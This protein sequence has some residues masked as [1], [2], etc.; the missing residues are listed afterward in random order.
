MQ[1]FLF[2]CAGWQAARGV[3]IPNVGLQDLG[4]AVKLVLIHPTRKN[5]LNK[6]E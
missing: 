5:V 2:L 4:V 3:H 1:L 6:Q